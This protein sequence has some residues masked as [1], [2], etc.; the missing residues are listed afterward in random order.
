MEWISPTDS[1]PDWMDS[2]EAARL[3]HKHPN[4]DLKVDIGG[5]LI[6]VAN[7][8]YHPDAGAMIIEVIDDSVAPEG[9][10]N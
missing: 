9:N 1:P 3:I 7:V 5:C 10:R 6:P 8:Y 2:H 4:A